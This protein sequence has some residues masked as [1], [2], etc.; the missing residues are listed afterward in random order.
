MKW[1]FLALSTAGQAAE[2]TSTGYTDEKERPGMSQIRYQEPDGSFEL[3]LPEGWVAERDEEGGLLLTRL[4]GPGLLHLIPFQRAP[5]EDVDPA[6]ELY[7]FLEEQEIELEDDEVEDVDLPGGGAL[8]LCEYV[9]EDEDEAVWWIVGV[10]TAP[11]Q[12]LFASYS[13]ALGEEEPER[14]QVRRV[15]AGLRLGPQMEHMEQME[16]MEQPQMSQMDAGM[17]GDG[18]GAES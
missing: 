14:E 18:G 16:Q 11:G 10:A 9:A 6:D 3:E 7:A 1:G 8:A 4:E 13:C 12:L 17:Q 5:E 2:M 15:L